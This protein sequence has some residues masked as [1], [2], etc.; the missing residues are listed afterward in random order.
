MN[1]F[2][3]SGKKMCKEKFSLKASFDKKLAME[4]CLSK[5]CITETEL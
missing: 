4:Q 3:A 2:R 1:A 5:I